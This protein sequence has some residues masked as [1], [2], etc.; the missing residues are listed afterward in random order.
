MNF[1]TVVTSVIVCWKNGC[2][3]WPI[4]T[5]VVRNWKSSTKSKAY[6][7]ICLPA[8]VHADLIRCL[9]QL[10]IMGKCPN[11]FFGSARCL[12]QFPHPFTAPDAI[13]SANLSRLA[14]PTPPPGSIIFI[15]FIKLISV[16]RFQTSNMD[17]PIPM[18]TNQTIPQNAELN[19]PAAVV[20]GENA[21]PLHPFNRCGL[22]LLTSDCRTGLRKNSS[23]PS[24]KHLVI[25]EG[26]SSDDMIT[27]GI[28]LKAAH[29][30][31]FLNRS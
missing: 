8:S 11:Q 23:A 20:S 17:S 29:P 31:I 15:V 6:Y 25:L 18:T 22:S 13:A 19:L 2:I 7:D 12:I 26:T 5:I 21:F 10:W 16:Q 14:S 27:T 9:I 1:R 28:S 3:V 24:A 4:H 30:L